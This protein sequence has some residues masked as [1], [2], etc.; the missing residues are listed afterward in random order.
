MIWEWSRPPPTCVSGFQLKNNVLVQNPDTP[1]LV[2]GDN[3]ED[4]AISRA[5]GNTVIFQEGFYL[6]PNHH[7]QVTGITRDTTQLMHEDDEYSTVLARFVGPSVVLGDAP[8]TPPPGAEGVFIAGFAYSGTL[9][10]WEQTSIYQFADGI[11]VHNVIH[12]KIPG[13]RGTQLV[14]ADKSIDL[15]IANDGMIYIGKVDVSMRNANKGEKTV[16]VGG[17]VVIEEVYKNMTFNCIKVRSPGADRFPTLLRYNEACGSYVNVEAVCVLPNAAPP[18]SAVV[19]KADVCN[20]AGLESYLGSIDTMKVYGKCAPG[21]PYPV[22]YFGDE[23][24]DNKHT[25]S[26]DSA[27]QM[28][29]FRWA[30]V[31]RDVV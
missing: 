15:V 27:C 24:D 29:R 16:L 11:T 2:V 3:P 8:F 21:E 6:G 12:T 28:G 5:E 23:E 18:G 31:P 17:K 20:V 14:A 4:P 9:N 30:C 10:M 19:N 1:I 22:I 25:L 7:F 26:S 13:V